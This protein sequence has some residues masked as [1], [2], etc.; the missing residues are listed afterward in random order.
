MQL[1]VSGKAWTEAC[2]PA[3]RGTPTEEGWP[4]PTWRRRGK[5]HQAVY[6]V[7]LRTAHLIADQLRLIGEA[8]AYGDD[9]DVRA[10]SRACL[11]A[12]DSADRQ[13]ARVEIHRERPYE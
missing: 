3:W 8:L 13:I 7:D 9:P 5:G 11:A 1:V 4:A 2:N 12:A 10:D 6:E